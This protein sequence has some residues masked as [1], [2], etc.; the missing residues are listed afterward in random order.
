MKNRKTIS[1]GV[2]LAGLLL[3]PLL[4]MLLTLFPSAR[5][6]PAPTLVEEESWFSDFAVEG[7]RVYFLCRLTIRNPLD[8]TVYTQITGDLSADQKGGLVLGRESAAF[9]LDEQTATAFFSLSAEEKEAALSFEAR[10]FPLQPGDNTFWAV[11][12]D[13]H[14]ESSVKQ[15]RLLPPIRFTMLED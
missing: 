1:R 9:R 12:W 7:D 11:F 13:L 5:H 14:G 4:A 8:E 15:D 3:L 6:K 2:F 10:L